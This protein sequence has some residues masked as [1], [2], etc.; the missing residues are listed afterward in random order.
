MAAQGDK[1]DENVIDLNIR[2]A[3]VDRPVSSTFS[4]TPFLTF[5]NIVIALGAATFLIFIGSVVSARIAFL[6]A[7]LFGLAAMMAMEMVSRR[8]WEAEI[9]EQISRMNGDYDRLVR[10]VARS[11]NE[12]M[13]LK[14]TLSDAG[15]RARRFGRIQGGED[16]VAVEQRMIKALADQLSRIGMET[17][18]PADEGNLDVGDIEKALEQRDKSGVIGKNLTDDQVLQL[19][20]AAVRQD[21]I[22]LFLQ[23]IVN[24]PQRKVRFREIFSRIRI[25]PE[26][27]LPAER[28]I[29]VA[30]RKD[31]AP[32]IDNLLLLRGLQLIR[33]SAE[34]DEGGAFFCNITS[35]TL[36][37]P[38]FMGDL[39]EFLAQ[40]RELAP[41][42]VFEMGQRDLAAMNADTLPVLEGLSRLGC[43]FSMDL[44]RSVSFDYAQLEARHIRFIKV[45][46]RRL[47]EELKDTGGLRRLKRM[48]SEL[49]TNGI[50]LIVEKI[51]SEQQLVELLD[52]EIDYGQGF[53]F[54]KPEPLL[55]ATAGEN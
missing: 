53:L 41:R 32:S 26:I 19:V 42:L 28:Y 7:A 54:G 21:R 43:R 31:L 39:V 36:N 5:R 44:V 25:K 52:L 10:E 15:E 29:E 30:I 37:D 9:G 1:R 18:A 3:A 17:G 48:K 38:K 22:D 50:D 24:L 16:G 49:D 14:K 23:P 33:D 55:L 20:R 4:L 12:M 46:A 34:A 13:S 2:R 51:E 8:K 35:L 6:F 45:E 47:L 27:Y 40:N 11:R